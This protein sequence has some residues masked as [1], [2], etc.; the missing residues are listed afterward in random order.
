MAI[1][2]DMDLLGTIYQIGRDVK[3]LV[4]V[5]E[6]ER[7]IRKIEIFPYNSII[8]S[9]YKYTWV[10][11]WRYSFIIVI[12]KWSCFSSYESLAFQLNHSIAVFY[13]CR[14]VLCYFIFVPLFFHP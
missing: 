5:G 2:R 12:S 7:F 4:V 8:R 11:G 3:H 9:I 10:G 14:T 13:R 1:S 6:R